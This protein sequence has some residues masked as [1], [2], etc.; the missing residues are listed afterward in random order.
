M[1]T[2][3]KT[4][5]PSGHKNT[6]CR[7]IWRGSI[8]FT[9][10]L[11]LLGLRIP[12][13]QAA[14][15][16]DIAAGNFD[17]SLSTGVPAVTSV[18]SINDM[19]VRAG[20]AKGI[21]PVQIG[22]DVTDDA[23]N[24]VLIGAV[25]Q[26]GRDNGETGVNRV[27][28]N[29][30]FAHAGL[31]SVLTPTAGYNLYSDADASV[32]TNVPGKYNINVAGAWFP[33]STWVGGRVYNATNGNPGF[34]AGIKNDTLTGPAGLTYSDICSEPSAGNYVLN[35][36]SLGIDSRTDGILLVNSG[37]AEINWANSAV[38]DEDGTWNV[39]VK[40]G[41]DNGAGAESDYFAF[42]F[43]PKTNT[44]V[45][46]GR[47][48]GNGDID[49]FS[50]DSPQFT[51]SSNSVGTYEL[52]IPGFNPTNGVLIVSPDQSGPKNLD[53][54]V[55]YAAN[56]ANNGWII[57][58]RD[59]P[60]IGSPLEALNPDEV[61]TSFVFIPADNDLPNLVINP[62]TVKVVEGQ[63][64]GFTVALKTQP[65]ADVTVNVESGNTTQGA[66][67]SPSILTFTP[68]NWNVPQLVILTGIDDLISDGNTLFRITNSA[69][70]ADLDYG[71][72]LPSVILATTLDNEPDVTLPSGTKFYSIG[73]SGIGVD[74]AATISDAHTATY[75]GSTLV[76]T[77]TANGAS[78]DRLEIR[79]SGTGAGQIS[80]AGN[81]VSYEGVAIATF[82]G[83]TGTT[84]LSVNFT[85]NSNPTNA[86][87]LLQAVI[88]RNVSSTPNTAPRSI[89]VVVTHPDGGFGS[90]STTINIGLLS[91]SSFQQNVDSGFGVYTNA[92]DCEIQKNNPF[93]VF[94]A[95][96]NPISG[97]FSD[98]PMPGGNANQ[99][100]MQF[101]NL[102]GDGPGQI[103]TN[104]IIVSADLTLRFLDSGDGSPLYRMLI[105][106][107]GN[108][109]TW[110]NLGG[111]VDLDD[112]EARSTYDSVIGLTSITTG[113]NN[114]P[115]TGVGTITFSVLADVLAWHGGAANYGWVLPGSVGQHD[116]FGV[117]PGE[118]TNPND[119]PQLRIRWVPAGT[120]SATFR[121][122]VNGYTSA[123]D[124]RIRLTTPTNESST[125]TSFYVDWAVS[126]ST[127]N[128]EQVLIKFDNIIGHLAGQIRLGSIV[129]AAVLDIN[130]TELSNSPGD[131]GTFHSMLAPWDHINSWADLGNG[132]SADDVEAVAAPSAV[133]GNSTLAPNIPAAFHTFELTADVQTWVSG[134]RPN[135]GWVILPWFD[136]GDGW[137]LHS[138]DAASEA[139]RPQLRVYYT[140]GPAPL[141]IQ[142]ITRTD[143][144]VTIKFSGEIGTNYS[145][146]RAGTVDGTYSV[147]G[148]ATVQPNGTATFDDNAPLAG[149]AFY[150]ISNP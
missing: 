53:N 133:A 17:V 102:F 55:T 20:A 146:R 96:G 92:A 12:S 41:G 89:S 58:T 9:I 74:G 4:K 136:G 29:Y 140:P 15:H 126:G 111:G 145:V 8:G 149:A 2:Q 113:T 56:A 26:N 24:G 16:H 82:S 54:M 44:T 11:A 52:K 64:N 116:G 103:P 36:T 65:T 144:T 150:R 118:S 132:V 119:R 39:R 61:V 48:L 75:N 131:G 78:D 105:P 23:T 95:G 121:Q 68:G 31:A 100:L 87:A 117:A 14:P 51:V 73:S 77:I 40:D 109:A 84:P 90:D 123:Q 28:T 106:F 18:L 97:L 47:F 88:F 137:G 104:A 125:A 32:T 19:Q 138:S 60:G 124:T 62:A 110:D 5:T 122:G 46:S 30:C 1:K 107:D 143:T 135:Y 115:N 85:A 43:I 50:G 42:V 147:I 3:K 142:S 99:V 128:D 45:V 38:N 27:G 70:S 59:Y 86:Q 79:S 49:V 148:S 81:T 67:V 108:S 33:F 63:T 34:T 25:S 101:G 129:H 83:G 91:V 57:Q 22:P 71:T 112:V 134:T 66:T 130:S 21:Y 37:K 80:V 93:T 7:F 127:N 139:Q 10:I 6:V 120:A 72:L 141:I 98:F 114:S 94:P 35:L 13:L 76:V 69:S